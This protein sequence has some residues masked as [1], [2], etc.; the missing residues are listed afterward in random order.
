M[1]NKGDLPKNLF[2][3]VTKE[4]FKPTKENSNIDKNL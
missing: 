2:E 4:T 3:A 1:F